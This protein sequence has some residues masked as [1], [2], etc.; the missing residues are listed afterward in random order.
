MPVFYKSL[1]MKFE[2]RFDPKLPKDLQKRY[3]ISTFLQTSEHPTIEMKLLKDVVQATVKFN[4]K[5]KKQINYA[6]TKNTYPG[7]SSVAVEKCH[8]K[9]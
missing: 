7:S 3:L 9:N 8:T 2:P 6:C 4:F 1:Y 5:Y